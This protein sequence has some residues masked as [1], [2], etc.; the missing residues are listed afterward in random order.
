MGRYRVLGPVPESEQ[1]QFTP[2]SI[3]GVEMKRLSEG[4]AL[5]AVEVAQ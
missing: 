2:A 5:V 1:W 4:E 3:V